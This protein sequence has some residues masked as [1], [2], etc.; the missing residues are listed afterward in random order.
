MIGIYKITSPTGRIY[1]GQ[2]VDIYYR[3]N[4]YK[5]KEAK[6]QVRLNRS[7][8]KHGVENHL[9]E[10]VEECKVNLLSDRERHWQEF[11]NVINGGLNC[12]LVTTKDKTG[13]FSKESIAKMSE[14]A[15]KKIITPE[16]RRKLKENNTRPM[17]GKKHTQE[18]LALMSKNRKGKAS[19]LG[20][21]LSDESKLKM[22]LK[23][24]GRKASEETKLKMSITRQAIALKNKLEKTKSV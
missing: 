4:D 7:F 8:K 3:W 5:T 13:H 24:T 2:S 20:A 10:V 23:A 21:V 11:Y 19:R 15:K 18:S 16:H 1:I 22:S 6:S 17:L 12:R 14:S 9:F